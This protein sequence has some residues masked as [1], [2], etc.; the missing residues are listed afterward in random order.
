MRNFYTTVCLILC[1]FVLTAIVEEFY[2]GARIRTKSRGESFLVAI[3][4]LIMK[5]K[6]RYGGYIVHLSIV[7][8][9]AGIAGNAFNR[10]ESRRLASGQ[11]MKI[12]NYSL[13]MTG[14][15]EGQTA[16]YNY[17]RVILE[18]YKNGRLI[19]TLQPEQRIFKSGEQQSTTTVA[20]YSTPKEDLYVVFAGTSDNG[21]TCE[22]KA[23]VN[24]LV[25]WVWFGAAVMVL[26]TVITLLPNRG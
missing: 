16:N 26:G 8:M 13:K 19:R 2:R 20:L 15:Q 12:G 23:Y 10:E 9:F 6:R 4:N 17:A 18:A 11:E 21:S 22:I 7:L 3:A 1:S 14:F 25:F 5:N 24:P